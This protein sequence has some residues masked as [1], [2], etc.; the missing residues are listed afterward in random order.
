MRSSKYA[1]MVVFL[2]CALVTRYS[3]SNCESPKPDSKKIANIRFSVS[4]YFED[5]R[6]TL[7][8]NTGSSAGSTQQ[9]QK[10]LKRWFHQGLLSAW[11]L[12]DCEWRAAASGPSACCA[13]WSPREGFFSENHLAKFLLL[14]PSVKPLLQGTQNV[15]PPSWH[16]NSHVVS[17]LWE[18]LYYCCFE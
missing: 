11:T 12:A 13:P 9:I 16:P 2:K 5:Y 4:I 6:L 8:P 14:G 15:A 3:V 1:R 7:K 10:T 18:I 17:R